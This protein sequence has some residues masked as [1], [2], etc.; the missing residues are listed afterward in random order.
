MNDSET[1]GIRYRVSRIGKRTAGN[2]Q[3]DPLRP[4]AH[5]GTLRMRGPTGI[6][7]ADAPGTGQPNQ[8][9]I[10]SRDSSRR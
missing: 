2:A 5:T 7:V 8:P 1:A 9:A 10:S 4:G 3:T 6:R